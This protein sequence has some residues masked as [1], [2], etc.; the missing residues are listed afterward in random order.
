MIFFDTSA[1]YALAD[2]ADENHQRAKEIFKQIIEGEEELVLHNYVVV[3][4][5]ALIQH[6]LGLSQVKKFLQDVE[7]LQILWVDELLHKKAI[8]YLKRYGKRKLSLVDCVSFA[9]MKDHRIQQA[10]AFDD[11]FEKA[12]F[13]ILSP[14]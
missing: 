11:D 10:F 6:R 9:I 3:E 4:S 8:A 1:V 7:L 2:R 13:E 14:N 5:V 12:G